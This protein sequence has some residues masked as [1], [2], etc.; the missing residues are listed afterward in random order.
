MRVLVLAARDDR[1]PLSAGGDQHISLLAR[2]LTA[3]GHAVTLVSAQHPTLR[4]LESDRGL[5]IR[6]LAPHRLLAPVLWFLLALGLGRRYDLIVEDLVNGERLPFL[7]RPLSRTPTVGFWFQDNRPLF[8]I[9]YGPVGYRLAAGLQS[10]LLRIYRRGPLLAPSRATRDWL[11]TQGLSGDRV[12]VYHRSIDPPT[13]ADP[14]VPFEGRTNR[15]MVVANF[16]AYK[17]MEEAIDILVSLR[18][19]IPD[20]T[21]TLLGRPDDLRYL[22]LLRRRAQLLPFPDAV[23]FEVGVSEVRKF[24]LLSRSKA[25]TV[26][27]PIEGLAWSLVEAGLSGLPVVV[28]SGVPPDA[29]EDGRSGVMVRTGGVAEYARTLAA[30]MRDGTLWSRYARGNREVA[31]EFVGTSL[32]LDTAAFL[33][34]SATEAP[35]RP[36][37]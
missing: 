24:E 17:R 22:A 29:F 36:R 12:H 4:S 20:A 10:I 18:R 7:A 32:P 25:L 30:W 31:S 15:F 26:H 37:R 11:L 33:Q 9:A 21:L 34:R 5:E 35:L 27:S 2:Q 14:T 16:R 13:A 19:V 1:N 6:R 8:R 28:S 3:A 23:A